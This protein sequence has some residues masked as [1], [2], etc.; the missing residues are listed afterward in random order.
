MSIALLGDIH[1]NAAAL[2]AVLLQA[3]KNEVQAL[4]VTGDLVGYYYRPDEVIEQLSMWESFTVRGNHENMLFSAIA[5]PERW[6][7]IGLCYGSG[8][9]RGLSCMSDRHLDFLARLPEQVT[10]DFDGCRILIVHGA[11]WDADEYIYPDA[12][13]DVWSGF[14][15]LSYDLVI[16]GH[17]H[18]RMH[19]QA[20]SALILNPGSVGQPRDGL[21][22]A[23]WALFDTATRYCTHHIETYD[24]ASVIAEAQLNDPQLPYLQEVLTRQ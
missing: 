9:Q 17:T 11:P 2:R 12:S 10:I 21:Q 20:G 19:K 13:E 16:T 24:I 5:S 22:G 4:F 18:Y 15:T 7:D 23:S 1:G 8:L 3:A 14:A 6:K